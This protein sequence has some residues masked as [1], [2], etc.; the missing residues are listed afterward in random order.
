MPV[1]FSRPSNTRALKDLSFSVYPLVPLCGGTG[2][3]RL[4]TC[5]I[6]VFQSANPLSFCHHYL[7][8][9]GRTS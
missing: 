6:L 7:A 5:W 1:G 3:G 2:G 4:R 8:V 9:I